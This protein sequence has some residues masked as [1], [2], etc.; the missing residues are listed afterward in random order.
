MGVQPL[1]IKIQESGV[2]KST[3]AIFVLREPELAGSY[4][5]VL[6]SLNDVNSL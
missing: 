6:L 2:E 1:K 5:P 3:S 4:W